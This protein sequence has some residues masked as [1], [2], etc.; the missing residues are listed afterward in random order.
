MKVITKHTH[1]P[2]KYIPLSTQMYRTHV[3]ESSSSS[4]SPCGRGGVWLSLANK[5]CEHAHVLLKNSKRGTEIAMHWKVSI[6]FSI[7]QKDTAV[8]SGWLPCPPDRHG[9]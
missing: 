4:G 1:E 9:E 3:N 5:R 6:T 7:E 8:R 2:R